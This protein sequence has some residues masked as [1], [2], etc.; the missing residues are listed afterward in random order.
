MAHIAKQQRFVGSQWIAI[1]SDEPDT[2]TLWIYYGD[3]LSAAEKAECEQ[4]ADKVCDLINED[5]AH[6]EAAGEAA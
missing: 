4:Y 1:F 5:A 2:S 6:S 3:E